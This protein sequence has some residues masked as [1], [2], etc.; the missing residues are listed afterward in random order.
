MYYSKLVTYDVCN[1]NG[2]RVS[3]FVSGCK[4]NCPGCFNPETHNPNYGQPF[5]DKT[6]ELLFR[7]LE[8]DTIDGLTI[9][10]GEPLSVLSD[11]R[12]TTI[13]LCKD[14][15]K[16]FPN[17]TI[18]LYTGYTVEEIKADPT[19]SPVLNLVDVVVDGPF[20]IELKDPNLKFRGSS[21]QRLIQT[22]TL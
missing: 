5:T 18:W 9:I 20:M 22:S 10:G 14:V 3:L 12:K 21:N 13:E 11:N 16:R 19:M 6:K 8:K 1:G 17:K 2:W 7:E 15:R 4:R